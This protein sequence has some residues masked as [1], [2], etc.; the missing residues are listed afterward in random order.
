MKREEYTSMVDMLI[1]ATLDKKIKWEEE[2]NSFSMAIGGC[3]LKL[4]S[5]YDFTVNASSYSLE[6]FNRDGELFETF[7]YSEDVDEANFQQLDR[8]YNVIRDIKLKISES[9][10]Y[11]MEGLKKLI[12]PFDDGLPF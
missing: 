6:L 7:S 11:I 3:K 1:S 8:L 12:N 4:T 10:K 9:E 5:S 2:A